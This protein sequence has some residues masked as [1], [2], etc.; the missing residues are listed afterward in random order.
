VIGYDLGNSKTTG[1]QFLGKRGSSDLRAWA[2][3]ALVDPKSGKEI[4]VPV[5]VVRMRKSGSRA[6]PI[7]QKWNY[8]GSHDELDR[9]VPF[10]FQ[11]HPPTTVVAHGAPAFWGWLVTP[12]P[13]ERVM[14]TLR[15]VGITAPITA[16]DQKRKQEEQRKKREGK[17]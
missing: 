4:W 2:E 11:F 12:Q 3:F 13:P 16:D 6:K 9:V 17:Q 8:F 15:F 14:Q 1:K 5:D 7:D 10:A